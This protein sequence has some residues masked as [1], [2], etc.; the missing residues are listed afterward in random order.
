MNKEELIKE[1]EESDY[2]V[3]QFETEYPELSQAFKIIQE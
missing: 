2:I 1:L 3:T